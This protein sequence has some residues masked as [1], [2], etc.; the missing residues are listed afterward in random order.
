M[1]TPKYIEEGRAL[2]KS[3]R[4]VYNY[5]KDIARP[6]QLQ[7]LRG[8]VDA[9]QKALKKRSIEDVRAAENELLAILGK[10]QPP[11][12]YQGIRENVELFVVA[13][14]LA[15]GI[16]AFYLQPFKIPTGSMQ[17]TL[18]G[19]IGHRTA[20]PPP[21]FIL[22]TFQFF[23]LGRTYEDV[24]NQESRD[25]IVSI[26]P[27]K[28]KKF[29]D[30]SVIQMSSGKTYEVGIDPR[31]LE[32]QMNV[33]PGQTFEKGEPIVRGYADLGDQLFVDKF[34]YNLIGPRRADVFVFRTN[35]IRGIPPGPDLSSEHYIKRLAG[36]PGDTLRIDQPKLF[37]NGHEA[38]EYAFQRVASQR[39]GYTG[40]RNFPGS[41]TYL[42]DPESTV[43]IP[44]E[45]YFALGDNSADSL[46]S[47]Y[48]GFVPKM[49]VV[50]KGLF[51]YWPFSS[52]WGLVR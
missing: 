27:A 6:E 18:N 50:G 47:R 2:V 8:K 45:N 35:G 7:R 16:R 33:R 13:I 19:V 11:R 48:W 15:L 43:T 20:T 32:Y 10:V 26:F 52:H 5:R 4:R 24:V 22:R 31:S 1:L 25:T 29:W 39:N 46:D 40:Y 38:T 28:V 41:T 37:V 23:T 17:P 34:S 21:N 42:G 14:V 36:L 51:V 9:L 44:P 30:G 3:A 12:E 49:N